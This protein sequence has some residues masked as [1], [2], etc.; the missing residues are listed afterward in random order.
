FQA[1]DCIR[2]R[3]VT[4]VQTCALPILL[5]LAA[6]FDV[7]P[8]SAWTDGLRPSRLPGHV[9]A[10]WFTWAL[11][12]AAILG[13]VLAVALLAANLDRRLKIGRASCRDGAEV[14][15]VA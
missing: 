7:R 4:G 15:R 12:A 2:D 3:N 14:S 1:E 6:R 13:V 9:A 10:E 11:A 5:G 8:F